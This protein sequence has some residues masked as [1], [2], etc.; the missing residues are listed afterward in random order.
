MTTYGTVR[1]RLLDIEC[2]AS[3]T[4][5]G[6]K[7]YPPDL[8]TDGTLLDRICPPGDFGPA[9]GDPTAAAVMKAAGLLHGT[10]TLAALP[11]PPAGTVY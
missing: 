8:V 10:F 2:S 5:D 9:D 7:V 3:L 1:F 11:G 4:S 6:W